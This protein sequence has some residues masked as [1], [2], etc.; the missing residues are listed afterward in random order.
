[1]ITGVWLSPGGDFLALQF[2]GE[3]LYQLDARHTELE[4]IGEV[5]NTWLTL[6]EET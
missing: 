4:P 2:D 3:E 6:H 5:P 1:V